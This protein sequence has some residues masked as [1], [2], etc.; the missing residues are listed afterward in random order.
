MTL[1]SQSSFP[2]TNPL[3]LYR[4][5]LR[6]LRSPTL[7]FRYLSPKLCYN[8]RELFEIHRNEQDPKKIQELVIWGWQDLEFL[9]A[10]KFVE[11]EIL[12]E[13]FRGYGSNQN[14]KEYQEY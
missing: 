6:Y 2:S 1:L 8:A 4:H 13:I 9:K 7:P 10:W 14:Y 3:H 11:K 12:D 5:T